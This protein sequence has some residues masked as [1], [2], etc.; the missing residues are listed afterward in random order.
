MRTMLLLVQSLRVISSIQAFTF[1]SP[2]LQYSRSLQVFKSLRSNYSAA[3]PTAMGM[4]SSS[5]DQQQKQASIVPRAA[6]SVVVRHASLDNTVKYVLVQR[7]NPPNKGNWSLPGGK[8]ELGE[9]SLAAAKRE[10]WEETGLSSEHT[11]GWNFE[12]CDKAPICTTDSIHYEEYDSH[13][14][15]GEPIGGNVQFHY[16]ISQWFVEMKRAD[17][18]TL[19][20]ARPTLLA[21]DDAADANWFNIDDVE[22]GI[23]KGEI[24]PGVEKVLIRSEVMY[25]KELL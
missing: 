2:V 11:E 6:V 21:S 8:I 9:Q 16:V 4:S 15:D 3:S 10:L 17:S 20:D 22:A 24:T 23:K 7:G 25:E 1:S 18:S 5:S 12:W 13:E 14:K 19:N